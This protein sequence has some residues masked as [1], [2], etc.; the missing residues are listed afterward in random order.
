MADKSTFI[1][2]DRN[3]LQWRWFND[4]NTF[5]VFVWL[6]LVANIS[7]KPF[8]SITVH[9]GQKAT[10]YGTIARNLAISYDQTRTAVEHLKITGE[11]TVRKYPKFLV[12]SI[13]NYDEYQ[14]KSQAKTQSNPMQVPCKSQQSKNSNTN[15]L[16]KKERNGAPAPGFEPGRSPDVEKLENGMNRIEINGVPFDFPDSYYRFANKDGM[17]I[18]D[19]V[20]WRN[21]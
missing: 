19:Y 8:E 21:P 9:R 14:S 15:V 2:I 7:D 1:K 10:S 17:T 12:I 18:K 20:K 3:I 13:T 4:A 11:I 5:R 6:L 16:L